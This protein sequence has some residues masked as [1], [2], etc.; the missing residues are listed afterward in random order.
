MKWL[1]NNIPNTL[2]LLNLLFG[3]IAAT[4]LMEGDFIG[5]QILIACSLIF[6]LFD[7]ALARLLNAKSALGKDLDSLADVVSFGF[8]PSLLI[9]ILMMDTGLI[10]QALC[11]LAFLPLLAAALRLAI[12]NQSSDQGRSFRGLPTPASAIVIMSL[13]LL[14]ESNNVNL[15]TLYQIPAFLFGISL[16]TSVLMVSRIALF[17]LK[18]KRFGLKENIHRYLMGFV[19]LLTLLFAWPVAGLSFLLFYV[20]I[21]LF[22]RRKILA[23][24]RS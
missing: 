22:F 11:Y 17:S 18:I 4:R 13:P 8:T 15:S 9:Y 5:A 3:A 16:L 2:T 6:D 24:E 20:S 23:D 14:W 12:F 21:S 1:R 7:G 10:A 19:M